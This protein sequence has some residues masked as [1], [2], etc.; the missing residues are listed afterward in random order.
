[1]NVKNKDYWRDAAIGD[2][3]TGIFKKRNDGHICFYAMLIPIPEVL[4]NLADLEY[5]SFVEIE[6]LLPEEFL[7]EHKFA[8][9]RRATGNTRYLEIMKDKK[10]RIYKYVY[11]IKKELL[12]NYKPLFSKIDELLSVSR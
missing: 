6:N 10:S 9:E 11:D 8:A 1:M 3:S 2:K 7:L 5:P 12:S 4:K